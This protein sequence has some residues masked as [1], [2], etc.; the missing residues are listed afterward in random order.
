MLSGNRKKI[1]NGRQWRG[2]HRNNSCT[3]VN[4][5]VCIVIIVVATLITNCDGVQF[6][7]HN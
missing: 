1:R 5:A 4:W 2:L 6:K 3:R 7:M